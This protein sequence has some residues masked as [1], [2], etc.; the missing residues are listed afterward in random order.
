[1]T[2]LNDFKA[3]FADFADLYPGDLGDCVIS[4]NG[5]HNLLSEI[6]KQVEE[7]KRELVEALFSKHGDPNET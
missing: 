6:D 2:I 3:R 1:M 4:R 7:E 5:W